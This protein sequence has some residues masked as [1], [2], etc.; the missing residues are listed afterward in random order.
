MYKK[1]NVEVK[2]L[3]IVNL[4]SNDSNF[5][6]FI[7]K[8]DPAGYI[9]DLKWIENINRPTGMTIYEDKLYVTTRF[10]L[11]IINIEDGSV[12]KSIEIP[13]AG[14]PN[15]VTVDDEGVAYITDS[16]K[17]TVYRIE[18]DIVEKWFVGDE[19]AKPNGILFDEG[20]IIVG[21]NSDNYL[22]SIDIQTKE[23]QNVAFLDE[24]AIDGIIKYNDAYLVSHVQKGSIYL[25]TK[26]GEVT[27]LLNTGAEDI[28]HADIGFIE[29]RKMII[30]PVIN[31]SKVIAYQF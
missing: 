25:V 11:L 7:S 9:I 2:N 29:T 4:N 1:C 27:E 16:G 23:I 3:K 5:V 28:R 18:N 30:S 31:K 12:E 15:D 17:K 24:G 19:I 22:K 26:S 6:E 20:K 14:F 10:S 8:V 21:V 13:D